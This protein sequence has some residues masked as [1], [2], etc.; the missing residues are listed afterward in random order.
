MC[1]YLWCK[2][3]QYGLFCIVPHLRLWLLN[4]KQTPFLKHLHST[5]VSSIMYHKQNILQNKARL[6]E[7]AQNDTK[8]KVIIELW[9]C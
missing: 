1:I 5:N 9:K 4:G 3:V 2:I 7:Q 8:Y 6:F